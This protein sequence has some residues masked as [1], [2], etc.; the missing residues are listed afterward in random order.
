MKK[1]I[2][3]LLV[4]VA[5]TATGSVYA[6]DGL[7]K[8]EAYLRP[9]LPVTLNGNAL[10]L[11][12]S[13]VMVDG[14]TYLKLRDIAAVTGLQ[15]NWNDNTQTVELSSATGGKNMTQQVSQ[16]IQPD[17]KII[18][19]YF[20][21]VFVN[22]NGTTEKEG[23]EFYFVEV[24]GNSYVS[25]VTLR[26]PFEVSWN[27]PTASFTIDGVTTS[28]SVSDSYYAGVDAFQVNGIT[29]FKL[30]NL[31]LT[32]SVDGDSLIITKQ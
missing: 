20:K 21:K 27:K 6:E 7:Q 30:S 11:E 12:S 22:L 31:G 13:P 26:E 17:A 23:G 9:S 16:E 5:I 28:I 2:M 15:V 14:S 24:D 8:I 1:F 18:P 32:A 10:K 19:S 29:V 25:A 3:G 4:G